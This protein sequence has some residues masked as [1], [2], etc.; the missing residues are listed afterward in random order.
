MAEAGRSQQKDKRQVR[1]RI[2]K[3]GL[4]NDSSCLITDGSSTP[5]ASSLETTHID[6]STLKSRKIRSGS[7]MYPSRGRSC[8]CQ[9][10][11]IKLRLIPFLAA[12][13]TENTLVLSIW[14]NFYVLMSHD[15]T[16]GLVTTVVLELS[17][18]FV[19]S[20]ANQRPPGRPIYPMK[21]TGE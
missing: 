4:K 20:R 3:D 17:T 11:P 1:S 8:R 7:G 10:S 2:H 16:N 15:A 13:I 21:T 6:C 18:T 14:R 19:R 12:N 9:R 5:T